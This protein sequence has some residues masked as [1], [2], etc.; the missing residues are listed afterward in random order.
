MHTG[1]T[2]EESKNLLARHQ[3][4]GV[5]AKLSVLAAVW[6]STQLLLFPIVEVLP[7]EQAIKHK[8]E[9]GLYV[10]L[11]LVSVLIWMRPVITWL[12]RGLSTAVPWF[13][14]VLLLLSVAT[15]F[16]VRLLRAQPTVLA[17]AVNFDLAHGQIYNSWADGY[18]GH[19]QHIY[20]WGAEHD[21]L[22]W[23][24]APGTSDEAGFSY[25]ADPKIRPYGV[26]VQAAS[27]AF[28]RLQ[29][30][31]GLA[32][33]FLPSKVPGHAEKVKLTWAFG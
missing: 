1:K 6:S 8:I 9:F 17:I 29:A 30:T 19:T 11:V 22:F 21:H 26:L 25:K 20:A 15:L 28:T 12:H 4:M 5:L 10:V 14:L 23:D 13:V 2:P 27:R 33:S 3:L 16:V 7:F 24:V 31:A 18:P 32:S